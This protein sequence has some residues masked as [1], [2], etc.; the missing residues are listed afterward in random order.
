MAIYICS[1]CDTMK[2]GDCFP[3]V[4]HP[5]SP[6]ELI[7]EECSAELEEEA[8]MEKEFKQMRSE[9]QREV[10]SGINNGSKFR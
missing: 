6:E 5:D 7:C 8:D 2:D 3:C 4:E 1:E 9:Y 10:E